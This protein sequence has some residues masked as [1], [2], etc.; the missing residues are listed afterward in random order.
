MRLIEEDTRARESMPSNPYSGFFRQDHELFEY[1]SDE[2]TRG[3]FY[4]HKQLL[5]SKMWGA[6]AN[7]VCEVFLFTWLIAYFPQ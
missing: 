2:L 5:K 6:I 3:E 7:I 4:H 1:N